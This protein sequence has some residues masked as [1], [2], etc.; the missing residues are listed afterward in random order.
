[1]DKT[2]MKERTQS[3]RIQTSVLRGAEKKVLEWM[4]VRMPRWVSSDML[5]VIGILGAVIVAVGYFLSWRNLG[6]LWLASLGLLDGQ[7]A[8]C[9]PAFEPKMGHAALTHQGVAVAGN[10]VTGQGLGAA[11]PFALALVEA[12]LDAHA[13]NEIA[14]AI[15]FPGDRGRE[16]GKPGRQPR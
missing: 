7:P 3:V 9:H 8:T 15:A 4:A 6:W 5:T 11:I 13:A 1:M 16:N 14:R 12:L 2:D 10:I